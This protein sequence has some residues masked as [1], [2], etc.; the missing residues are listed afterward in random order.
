MSS[1][2]PQLRYKTRSDFQYTSLYDLAL[3]Y[4]GKS[5]RKKKSKL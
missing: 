4:L 3:V 1:Q 5:S 2:M